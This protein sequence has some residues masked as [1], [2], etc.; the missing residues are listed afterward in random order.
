MY[1]H[2]FCTTFHHVLIQEIGH[3]SLCCIVGPHCSSIRNGHREQTYG[4]QRGGKGVGR[5]GSVRLIDANCYVKT[6]V[7]IIT[8][9][10]DSHSWM[11]SLLGIE[12]QAGTSASWEEVK[13]KR[14]GDQAG[15][16]LGN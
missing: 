7:F 5:T 15:E 4:C 10:I 14:L 3:S 12:C 16:R 2:F 8:V 6:S 1:V 13:R 9:P 11:P